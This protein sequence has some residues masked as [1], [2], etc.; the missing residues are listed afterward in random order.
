MSDEKEIKPLT[1]NEYQAFKNMK[2][3]FYYENGG[4]LQ[5]L[6]VSME[7]NP[8]MAESLDCFC[9]LIYA[10]DTARGNDGQRPLDADMTLKLLE[11]YMNKEPILFSM[12]SH[13][14]CNVLAYQYNLENTEMVY[15]KVK[16]YF[17][18]H[19]DFVKDVSERENDF[20]KQILKDNIVVE[21]DNHQVNALINANSLMVTLKRPIDN[22]QNK[23]FDDIL[24]SYSDV[25]S[26]DKNFVAYQLETCGLPIPDEI[27]NDEIENNEKRYDERGDI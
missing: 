1:E 4:E 22:I 15:D 9:A 7:N 10:A 27:K 17:E 6:L 13:H 2:E 8:D 19:P 5:S 16:R 14:H 11:V 23:V 25:T 21:K 12:F 3:K 24:P 26:A 20:A 18:K